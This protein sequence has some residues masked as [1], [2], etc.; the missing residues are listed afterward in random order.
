MSWLVAVIWVFVCLITF[1][2]GVVA[3]CKVEANELHKL[4]LRRHLQTSL[5]LVPS[6]FYFLECLNVFKK[7]KY[8]LSLK[9]LF[10]IAIFFSTISFVNSVF[11]ID[12]QYLD[13]LMRA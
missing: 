3:S 1:G 7:H 12:F 8:K 10:W 11:D 2:N 6:I 13:A 4:H 5:L 9:K